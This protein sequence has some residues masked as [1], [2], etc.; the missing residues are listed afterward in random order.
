MADALTVVRNDHEHRYEAQLDGVVVAYSKFRRR[1]G[2]LVF[3]HTE[4]EPA[5]E[6]RGFGSQ[7]ARGLLDD[8][9]ARGE[10]LVPLCPFIKAYIE[11]HPEYADVVSASEE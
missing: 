10:Q 11:K 7:L 2:Q 3:T 6:G 8:V 1:P 9:R 4:T 5:Y